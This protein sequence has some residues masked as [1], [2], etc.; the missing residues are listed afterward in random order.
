MPS[1]IRECSSPSPCVIGH[2]SPTRVYKPQT[3]PASPKPLIVILFGGG[4]IMGDNRQI[5]PTAEVLSV[6]YGATVVLPSYRLSPEHPF[7]V[8]QND[9]WDTLVWISEHAKSA[10]ELAAV[11]DPSAGFVLCGASSGGNIAASIGQHW[12]DED[13]SL[14]KFK[15]VGLWLGI[16]SIF[17]GIVQVPEEFRDVFLSREQNKDADFLSTSAIEFVVLYNRPDPQSPL[18]SPMNSKT[19]WKFA[20]QGVRVYINVCGI[21]PLRDDGLMYEGILRANGVE[22]KLDVYPGVSLD[23]DNITY[24]SSLTDSMTGP[25][26][27]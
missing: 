22:T 18:A 20:D 10:P 21:D 24:Q 14:S 17:S 16:P 11:V 25:A 8:A 26:W 2:L 6:Q 4:F 1:Q 12:V 27:S 9:T 15:L 13:P 19:P 7:P 5:A 23:D 3:P